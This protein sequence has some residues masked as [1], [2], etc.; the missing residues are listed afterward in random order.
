[1]REIEP[2][3]CPK[4][5]MGTLEELNKQERLDASIKKGRHIPAG[6]VGCDECQYIN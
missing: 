6:T 4:C 2:A 3:I 5:Q 1:M